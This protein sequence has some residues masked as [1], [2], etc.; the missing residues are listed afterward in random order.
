MITL[1]GMDSAKVGVFVQCFHGRLPGN[2]GRQHLELV[3]PSSPCELISCFHCTA[4]FDRRFGFSLEMDRLSNFVF[5][6]TSF[7]ASKAQPNSLPS[8]A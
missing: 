8:I 3:N 4:T 5:S 1:G 6:A 2:T 7:M